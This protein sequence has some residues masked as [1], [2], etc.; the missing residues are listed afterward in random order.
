MGPGVTR[1][2]R[3]SGLSRYLG[4]PWQLL[5]APG[6][7]CNPL[8]VRGG[9][10]ASARPWRP[11][12]GR[13]S[14]WAAR[15]RPWLSLERPASLWR[16]LAVAGGA[17]K[18]PAAPGCPWQPLEGPGCLRQPLAAAGCPWE[19]C[20]TSASA[21]LLV[22]AILQIAMLGSPLKHGWP[23]ASP[24]SPW[25]SG[26]APGRALGCRWHLVAAST[27]LGQPL[28]ASDNICNHPCQPSPARECLWLPWRSPRKF[29]AASITRK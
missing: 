6:G 26:D 7:P 9:L 22:G 24:D 12:A 16:P 2:S 28:A 27:R 1:W 10:T 13:G 17:R 11:L 3:L 5:A 8:A 20:E 19:P 18:P 4:G 25:P 21:S 23:L 29:C 14:T 15:G